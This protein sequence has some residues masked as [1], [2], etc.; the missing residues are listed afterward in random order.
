MEQATWK[1]LLRVISLWHDRCFF[2]EFEVESSAAVAFQPYLSETVTSIY[3]SQKHSEWNL[4]ML[5]SSFPIFFYPECFWMTSKQ[6][7]FVSS[8]FRT[9]PNSSWRSHIHPLICWWFN[10]KDKSKTTGCETK[11]H[12]SIGSN[13]SWNKCLCRGKSKVIKLNSKLPFVT[14]W[15]LTNFRRLP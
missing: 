8:F 11:L 1:C 3:A 7:V 15:T 6:R 4:C 13:Y 5:Q 10:R 2:S 14:V 12:N 9:I